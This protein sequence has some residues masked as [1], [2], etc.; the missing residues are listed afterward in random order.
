MADGE[1]SMR[2]AGAVQLLEKPSWSHRIGARKTP[3]SPGTC[4]LGLFSQVPVPCRVFRR[5]KCDQK[6][7]DEDSAWCWCLNRWDEKEGCAERIARVGT[8]SQNG[9]GENINASKRA[10]PDSMNS[11][12]FPET[13]RLGNQ[14]IF[15]GVISSDPAASRDRAQAS[16]CRR[17]RTYNAAK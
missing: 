16:R 1:V 10:K 4:V 5:K 7:R 13:S 2:H 17:V 9:Y 8:L 14:V 6:K 15:A 11:N 12:R 3:R